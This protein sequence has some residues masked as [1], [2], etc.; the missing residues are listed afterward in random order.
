MNAEAHKR[1]TGL[2]NRSMSRH[3]PTKPHLL[4]PLVLALFSASTILTPAYAEATNNQAMADLF[5]AFNLVQE[6]EKA[7]GQIDGLIAD[8]NHALSL[9]ADAASTTDPEKATLLLDQA[10]A[11]AKGVADE[12]PRVLQ[13]GLEAK[14]QANILLVIELSTLSILAIVIY[15][16]SPRLFWTLWIKAYG[17]WK[18]KRP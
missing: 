2:P 11:L 6:A 4:V 18:V 1:S 5:H 7:G 8:L 13:Q 10:K 14:R 17:A 15:L 12:A 16:Y 3:L 9:I